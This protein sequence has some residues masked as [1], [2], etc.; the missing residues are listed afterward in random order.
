MHLITKHENRM[1]CVTPILNDQ[2]VTLTDPSD[3]RADWNEYYKRL[4]STKSDE[5]YDDEFKCKIEKELED[6]WKHKH[7]SKKLKGG[8]ITVDE[9]KKMISK[10]KMKK[11]SGWDQLTAEHLKNLGNLGFGTLTWIMN[12]MVITK[13]I[14]QRLKKGLIV[15]IPKP[16]KD[17]SIKDQ[18]RGLT[19]LPVVYKLFEMIIL[20]REKKWLHENNVISNLQGAAQESCS[21][22]H[23]S[24][25]LQETIDYNR[26][27]GETVYM[28]FLDIQKAFDTVWV[29][30]LIYK[31]FKLGMD[32]VTVCIINESFKDF[33]CT[34]YIA[35]ET[36]SWFNPQRGVHQ[37]APL[38]MTLYEI[39]I[40][41]LLRQL[42]SSSFGL[43]VMG[44][45]ATCPSYADDISTGTLSKT[46]LNEL[47]RIA[48]DYQ[49][50]WRYVFS[51]E[52]CVYMIW[53]TDSE[54][55]LSVKL[56]NIELDKVTSCKHMGIKISTDKNSCDIIS[57]RIG[58][59]R[60]P[61]LCARGLGSAAVPVTPCVLSKIYNSVCIPRMLYGYEA[62]YISEHE[63]NELEQ[64][65]RYHARLIQGLP[66]N[67]PT[68]AAL[69]PLGWI[70][71]KAQIAIKKLIFM[72]R[73]LTFPSENIYRKM[74][75]SIMLLHLQGITHKS[76][77]IMQTIDIAN[78]YG[79]YDQLFSTLFSNSMA[80]Y[81]VGKNTITSCVKKRD[82]DE[83][84]ATCMMY[85]KLNIYVLVQKEI[86]SGVW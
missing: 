43:R 32:P 27:K 59:A 65:H 29:E 79:L 5:N 2:G 12:Y 33:Q 67:V 28:A 58:K 57:E 31:L 6:I 9:L 73:I 26:S 61:L 76:S 84:L 51:P 54:P 41:E 14:P 80:N 86:R 1:R 8:D 71:I 37:G 42:K 62:T 60:L 63:I 22:V 44:L 48:N 77:P 10:L 25:L 68:P 3:I 20:E 21:S 55:D 56:G 46:G 4:Y 13:S 81:A 70:S 17:S 40:D 34:A 38:S 82:R 83:W 74:V 18:N 39:Y 75:I 72:W 85:S 30:G 23:V 45:N 49:R 16:G 11:A 69:A 24:L 52:K 47:L 35:G 36:S 78:K 53:G 64:A 7:I 15:P 50:R 66:Q 19:L